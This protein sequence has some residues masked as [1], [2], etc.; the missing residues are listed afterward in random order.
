MKGELKG[1]TED[2]P[3]N[4]MDL[5]I[6][7]D[8]QWLTIKKQQTATA[9]LFQSSPLASDQTRQSAV[10]SSDSAAAPSVH[11]DLRQSKLTGKH[12]MQ[13]LWT[14]CVCMWIYSCGS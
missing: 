12:L 3:R 8:C 10:I 2:F 4:L 7:M 14:V 13:K 6:D 11:F 5:I 9:R 1:Y